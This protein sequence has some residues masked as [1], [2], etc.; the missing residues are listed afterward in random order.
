MTKPWR[1]QVEGLMREQRLQEAKER[2]LQLTEERPDDPEVW[3]HTAWVHDS[4]GLEREAVPYYEKALTYGL[5]GNDLRDALLGLGSTYRCLGEYNQAVQI[6]QTGVEQ[7]PD[8]RGMKVFLAMALYNLGQHREAMELLLTQL[9]ETTEDPT[10][11]T[12]RKALSFYAERLD[13]TWE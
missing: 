6:L 5:T 9:L 12:Y 11:N 7:F 8:H 1:N 2:L 13:E 4:L 3:V 10:I